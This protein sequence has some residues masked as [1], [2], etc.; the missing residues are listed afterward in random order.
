MTKGI[1]KIG[2]GSRI[3]IPASECAI[4]LSTGLPYK[5]K[6]KRGRHQGRLVVQEFAGF[7]LS[8]TGR[9]AIWLCVCDCGNTICTAISPSVRVHSCGC[10]NREVH[11]THGARTGEWDVKT[12]E[13][14]AYRVW[15]SQVRH[16]YNPNSSSYPTVGGRGIKMCDRWVNDFAAFLEDV[17]LPPTPQD[18]LA[19][20][21]SDKDFE[22]SN[23]CWIPR[24]DHSERS[25]APSVQRKNKD[26]P[27]PSDDQLRM[28]VKEYPDASA[29]EYSELF[30]AATGIQ[31][32]RSA[33]GYRLQKLGLSRKEQKPSNDQLMLLV[34]E[35][36]D[37][38]I[39]KYS[40]LLAAATGIRLSKSALSH[41]LQ[42]LELSRKDQRS[43]NYGATAQYSTRKTKGRWKV[44]D[45]ARVDI[46]ASECAIELS[47][48]LP[49]NVKDK[50][51]VRQGRLVAQEFAG[52]H[53]S[54][55]RR[56]VIWLC[57]CDCGNT[58]RARITPQATVYSCGCL[59][60]EVNT[61]HGAQAWKDGVRSAEYP[62]YL[63][64]R[65]QIESCYHS[66][67]PKYPNA[68]GRGIKMYEPWVNDFAA[69]LEDVGYPPTPQ[70]VLARIDYDK[71]FEPSN[72]RWI[73]RIEHME[74]SIARGNQQRY[75]DKPQPSD[76]QLRMLVK[77][78]PDA[79]SGDYCELLAAATGIR[80]SRS[81]MFRRLQ[82]LGLSRKEQKPS[83]DQ[84]RMLAQQYPD[85][86]GREYCELLAEETG[87]RISQSHLSVRMRKLG[88][89]R[90]EP[91]LSDD[92]LIL[93]A[94]RYP[95]AIA[96]DYCELIAKETGIRISRSNM[97]LRLQ[98]LGVSRKE[99]RYE[100]FKL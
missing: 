38:S 67:S 46:P 98:K 88:L 11:T 36:P 33:M 74:R 85:A 40:E 87:I 66:H 93:F 2:D 71:D 26:K 37:A 14:Q 32:S 7:Q 92:Q 10:L 95:D 4:E 34:K 90:E 25:I 6:D 76:D 42:K 23:V 43:A 47:T 52:F 96:T 57:V 54:R 61:T 70:H 80:I 60:R 12:A 49:D 75:E 72:V 15:L 63:A 82:K 48:G 29:R 21:D 1:R 84:L 83:D 45:G 55:T 69:F 31:I 91:K 5:V 24:T 8:G 16:C 65:G 99:Q 78:Y 53:V 3:D 89:A 13:I 56:T 27:K 51:G 97:Q 17:G 73:P 50:R 81:S 64:W 77:K 22:P 28:L 35:Y 30:A 86:T 20:L 18:V 68:G 39:T 94:Q 41:R 79:A 44:G 100:R 58:T 19:R 62:V 9:R 59:F